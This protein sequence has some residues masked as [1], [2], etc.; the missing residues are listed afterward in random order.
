MIYLDSNVFI[1]AAL[2]D[3]EAGENSRKIIKVV[4]LGNFE[5]S[6][7]TL[8]FDE[9]YWIVKRR[10]DKESALKIVKSMLNM[11]NLKFIPVDKSLLWRTYEFLDDKDLG[12]RDSIHLAC[13]L[14]SGA[15]LIVSDDSDFDDIDS[16]ENIKIDEFAERIRENGS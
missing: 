15:D 8:T 13:A 1:S 3:D 7:S 5:A 6:T 4:R 16:I 11:K 10:R 12:P 14:G 2:Y 9:V